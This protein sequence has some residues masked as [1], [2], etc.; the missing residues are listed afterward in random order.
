[1]LP[2]LRH[3]LHH[4]QPGSLTGGGACGNS[5][6]LISTTEHR[7]RA[8]GR[9]APT[10]LLIPETTTAL[11]K[12]QLANTATGSLLCSSGGIFVVASVLFFFLFFFVEIISFLFFSGLHQTGGGRHGNAVLHDKMGSH[13][14][15]REAPSFLFLP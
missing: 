11:K 10:P 8:A 14:G 3:A 7:D 2:A 4:C 15:P 13:V 5:R 9:G 12:F 6:P 1:M